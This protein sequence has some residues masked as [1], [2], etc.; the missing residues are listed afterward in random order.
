MSRHTYYRNMQG[1]DYDEDDDYDSSY[2]SSYG[3]YCKQFWDYTNN[4]DHGTSVQ[5]NT[6]L[7]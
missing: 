4:P 7:F 5:N 2:G 3:K 6:S 1:D